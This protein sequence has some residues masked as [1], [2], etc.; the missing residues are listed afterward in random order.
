[1]AD[2]LAGTNVHL[3][4]IV[5]IAAYF[6]FVL[7]VGLWSSK[8]N[9]GSAGGYFLA[10]RNMNW[11]P[12]GAS[13]FAS[14]I[15]SLHFVGLAGSGAAAGIAVANY[16]LNAIMVLMLLGYIFLPVYIASGV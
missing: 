11:I 1:M 14:N 16:E 12:V 5:V 13:L 9:R 7:F 15:G 6:A 4:D 2:S 8:Q 3:G 10:G